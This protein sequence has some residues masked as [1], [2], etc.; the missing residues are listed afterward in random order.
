MKPKP[1]T[2]FW[3]NERVTHEALIGE[4]REETLERMTGQGRVLL[5]QDTTSLD[6]SG[7]GATVG[8]GT[9]ENAE[10][11]GLFAHSTLA[12]SSAGKPLGLVSQ[13]VWV[14]P[15]EELG[16]RGKRHQ[17]AFEDKESYKWVDGLRERASGDLWAQGIT[18]CDRE[19]H[20][21]EFLDTTL[22]AK[23]DFIVRAASGRSFTVD[24]E[25]VFE[26]IRFQPVVAEKRLPVK[27]RPDRE[28][29]EATVEVRFGSL[30]LR[31]PQRANSARDGL[32][33]QVVE[34][35]EGQAPDGEEPI[36]WLLLTSLPVETLQQAEQVVTF[37]TYR[38]LIERFH[39][40]L[41]SGCK[42]EDSQLRAEPRL[43]RLLAVYSGV[44]W[45]LLWLT[46]QARLTPEASCTA[47]L[48]TSEWQALYA[49]T[50][51]TTRL[52][53]SPP[54]LRQA[55]RW[56]AQL[57]GFLGRKADGDPGVKVLWRGW[58]RLQDIV[59]TWS[60]AHPLQKDVG[61]A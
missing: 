3:G 44:A 9:L 22:K 12:V 10:C 47:V 58:S 40:T 33:V 14:R 31:R 34:V 1:P 61:N 24:G 13:R 49:F 17:T 26:A 55:I 45:H 51:R 48:T 56:I 28:A 32:T 7:H 37:Y 25:E 5:V 38:W 18:V 39:Y 20:I 2:V 41:K 60:I 59:A 6:F 21:Y 16:K 43:E 11:R 8:L 35:S 57:G 29:R 53:A 19:A 4:L 27:R 42:L 36:H 15:E 23:L 50:Q 54:T 46:Y 52:P 30:T